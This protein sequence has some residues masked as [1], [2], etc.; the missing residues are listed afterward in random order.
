MNTYRFTFALT[1]VAL[2]AIAVAVVA[3][4]LIGLESF[5]GF[6]AALTVLAFAAADYRVGGRTLLG[7]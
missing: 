6:G 1:A 5:V 3:G 7:K 4:R 2:L